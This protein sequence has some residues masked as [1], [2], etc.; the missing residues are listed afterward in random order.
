MSLLSFLNPLS[1]P[2][3]LDREKSR[4]PAIVRELLGEP[5]MAEADYAVQRIVYGAVG[6]MVIMAMLQSA[7]NGNS[8]AE[9]EQSKDTSGV[10]DVAPPAATAA[11]VPVPSSNLTTA[12]AAQNSIRAGA[13]TA[14][15]LGSSPASPRDV[16]QSPVQ[17]AWTSAGT[18]RAAGGWK[19]SGAGAEKHNPDET[20]NIFHWGMKFL[21]G[22]LQGDPEAFSLVPG[23]AEGAAPAPNGHEAN[24]KTEGKGAAGEKTGKAKDR[25]D[26]SRKG[27][28]L[29]SGI[30]AGIR[31]IA[32]LTAREARASVPAATSAE[33]A[34]GAD[35][36]PVV[37]A[38]E[39]KPAQGD[40]AVPSVNTGSEQFLVLEPTDD[41]A[42]FLAYDVI[43]A[44][45]PKIHPATMSYLIR[46]ASAG[47]AWSVGDPGD[48]FF[49]STSAAG[50][51]A[52]MRKL[53]EKDVNFTT[54][55]LQL[56][57]NLLEDKGVAPEAALEP[58]I[59]L[60]FGQELLLREYQIALTA[61]PDA[62]VAALAVAL[63]QFEEMTRSRAFVQVPYLYARGHADLDE[64]LANAAMQAGDDPLS[65]ESQAQADSANPSEPVA[66]RPMTKEEA[67]KADESARLAQVRAISRRKVAKANRPI[68]QDKPIQL[69][70]RQ[71]L[72]GGVS[73]HETN[74]KE[75]GAQSV[76]GGLSRVPSVA[77]SQAARSEAQEGGESGRETA[78]ADVFSRKAPSGDGLL[79]K[80]GGSAAGAVF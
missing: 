46:R 54:G 75:A 30:R 18:S 51:R 9:K 10:V 63:R 70:G 21:G 17:D 64:D 45:A 69:T 76:E 24:R 16:G 36:V 6:V 58:C 29:E 5:R 23:K 26:Q 41:I 40:F 60:R 3:P 68:E 42:G 43:L 74:P 20:P 57:R 12:P 48:T 37:T 65:G 28:F 8:G 27:A 1:R 72:L 13:Q 15:T 11:P 31:T 49:S 59:N 7:C 32:A 80:A 38:H 19:G 73:G 78:G 66:V 34:S 53:R 61:S 39:W 44:C 25:P 56:P 67:E 4:A 52:V 62:P 50:A 47:Q 35:P 77:S 22:R 55:L 33:Q 14:S 2:K 79:V 71:A